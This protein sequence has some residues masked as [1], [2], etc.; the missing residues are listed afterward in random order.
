MATYKVIQDI[1]AEDKLLG[2]LTLK[3]FIFASITVL[4]LYL[5]F[6]FLTKGLGFF[7]I[8]LLP[9]AVFFGVLAFPWSKTQP[10]EIWLLAKIRYFFKP[11]KRIWDQ[12]GMKQLVTVTAPK[13]L[14][15]HLTDGLSQREVRSRLSALANTIDSR[16]WAV[17]NVNVNLF[18]QAAYAT[19][20]GDRL[21][22]PSNLPQDV[23]FTDVTATDDMMDE[24]NNPTAQHLEQMI[25]QSEKAHRDKIVSSMNRPQNS[26]Q[27]TPQDYWFMHQND[28]TNIPQGMTT[29]QSKVVSPGADSSTAKPNVSK[30]EEEQL[31]EKI[32][33]KQSKKKPANT[34]LKTIQPLSEQ[35]DPQKKQDQQEKSANTEDKQP[36]KNSK[37]PPTDPAIMGLAG[38]D[39]LNISTIS[40]IANKK[41]QEPPSDEVVV[42]LR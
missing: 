10:T 17:K 39:D 6:I 8:I 42:N 32:H 5:S 13:Q 12:S 3:Q 20:G 7:L 27:Q 22:S 38:N 18:S 14:E 1:E 16:G 26:Q 28:P 33:N 41:D 31:L 35:K 34:H 23:S 40:R 25:T 29:A 30:Q 24:Q 2:P 9:P 21:V 37:K 11:R 15:K 36:E 4:C 19:Q